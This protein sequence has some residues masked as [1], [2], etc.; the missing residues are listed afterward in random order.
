MTFRESEG[1]CGSGLVDII[2]IL[3]QNNILS[4]A[5]KLNPKVGPGTEE[6]N[7]SCQ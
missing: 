5:G 2:S 3:L 4:Q 1:I 6:I 7:L